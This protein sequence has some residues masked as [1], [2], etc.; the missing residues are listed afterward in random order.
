MWLLLVLLVIIAVFGGVYISPLMLL[1]L[2]VAFLAGIS[3]RPWGGR[4][5]P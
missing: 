2:I 1:L 5:L 4:R 3:Q